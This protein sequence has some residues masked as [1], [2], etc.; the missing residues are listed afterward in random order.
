[1]ATSAK[2]QFEIKVRKSGGVKLDMF[3]RVIVVDIA[4]FSQSTSAI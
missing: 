3:M 4:F 1:M 2:G